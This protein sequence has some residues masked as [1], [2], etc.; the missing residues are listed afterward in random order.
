MTDKKVVLV[1]GASRGIGLAAVRRLVYGTPSIPASRVVTLSRTLTE[2]LAALAHEKPDDL[3]TVQG[4]VTSE[5]DNLS[6]RDEALKRWGRLDALILNAGIVDHQMCADL[7]PERFMHVLN[8]N[9][10]SLAL[11]V[12]IALPELRKSHGSVVFVSSGS[13]TS[14]YSSWAAYK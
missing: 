13:A 14:N 12:R 11:T 4:D 2:D 10:V 1:T 7:T 6:A 9:T 8:V 3:V 5:K